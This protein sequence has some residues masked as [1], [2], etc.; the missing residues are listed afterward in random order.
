V[1]ADDPAQG[2]DV[3]AQCLAI[4][5]HCLGIA[6]L[7]GENQSQVI[8]RPQCVRMLRPLDTA[9]KVQCLAQQFFR[10]GIVA[11]FKQNGGQVIR[12]GQCL[13]MLRPQHTA[14]KIQRFPIQFFRFGM[15]ALFIDGVSQF[16]HGRHYFRMLRLYVAALFGKHPAQTV[17]RGE[18][19]GIPWPEHPPPDVDRR[20]TS[21][22]AWA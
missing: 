17:H 12:R 6:A 16:I 21:G 10:L 15:M 22:S 20:V 8:H 14:S 3:K 13:G 9:F 4:Q 7:F 18:G 2:Y 11:L 1:C 19:V 5:F